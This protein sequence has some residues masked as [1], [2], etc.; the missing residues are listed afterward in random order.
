MKKLIKDN[1]F[2]VGVIIAFLVAG[3]LFLYP[4]DYYV[5]SPGIAQDI[6]PMV[7]IEAKSY[8]ASGKIMLTTVSMKRANVVDYLWV[9][10]F[11]PELYELQSMDFLPQDVRLEEYFNLMQEMMKESQLKA[12]AIAL[13]K[14]GYQPQITGQGVEI[15]QVLEKSN[16]YGRLEEGDIIVGVDGTPVQLLTETVDKIKDRELG[17]KVEI[18]VKRGET[19]KNYSIKTKALKKNSQDPSIGVLIS[20]YKRKYNFPIKIKIDAGKIGGPSAGS[21]FALEIYN[22]LT[23]EDIT[24]GNKIAGTGTIDLEGKISKIDGI[25]QKIAAAKEEGAQ[26]FFV[27]A[28][29]WELAQEMKDRGIKLVKV[30][31]FN[32]IIDYLQQNN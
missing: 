32:D 4:I 9:K 30:E 17:D 28:G 5:V 22:K 7:K 1:Q 6:S 27:P 16:G 14:V 25:K 2:I 21:M 12:Q 19:E 18:T 11:K 8:A 20:P 26:L 3:F 15:V 23:K 31:K 24:A 29:N 13:E 10:I